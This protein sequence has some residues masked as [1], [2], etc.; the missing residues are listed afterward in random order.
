MTQSIEKKTS[1][2]IIDT[3]HENTLNYYMYMS[4]AQDL[5]VSFNEKIKSIKIL[6][7]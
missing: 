7:F 5:R 4:I 2:A 1:Q 6:I 3:F